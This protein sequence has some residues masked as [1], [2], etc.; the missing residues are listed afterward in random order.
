MGGPTDFVGVGVLGCPVHARTSPFPPRG[1][2][3]SD[4]ELG[5]GCGDR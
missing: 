1:E 5:L 2:L 4:A 3:G